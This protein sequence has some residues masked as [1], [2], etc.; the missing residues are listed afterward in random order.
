MIMFPVMQR[1]ILATVAFLLSGASLFAQ[2][3]DE[4]ASNIIHRDPFA[5]AFQHLDTNTP[6]LVLDCLT[7]PQIDYYC[8]VSGSGQSYRVRNTPFA[9]QASYSSQLDQTTLKALILAIAA[10]PEPPKELLASDRSLVVRGIRD[11]QWFKNIY[12]RAD[13]PKEVE[14]LFQIAGGHLEWYLRWP[15][16]EQITTNLGASE[17]HMARNAPKALLFA[18]TNLIVFDLDK[19][20]ILETIPRTEVLAYPDQGD[21]MQTRILSADGNILVDS[22]YGNRHGIYAYDLRTRK[23]LWRKDEARQLKYLNVG[24]DRWQSLFVGNGSSIERWDLASGNR[25]A[26]LAANLPVMNWTAISQDGRVFASGYG[27]GDLKATN[28]ATIWRTDEDKPVAKIDDIGHYGGVLSP[29]GRVLALTIS[30]AIEII[31]WQKGSRTKFPIRFPY[32]FHDS[33]GAVYWSPD[34]K[35]LEVALNEASRWL[36][37]IYETTA[38]KPKAILPYRAEFT[39]KG[40]LFQLNGHEGKHSVQDIYKVTE[41]QF[42]EDRK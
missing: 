34:G 7:A 15:E 40:D 12:D 26:V 22:I 17:F 13:I 41:A 11:N 5:A 23:I 25:E 16:S 8:Q 3:S 42:E 18:P 9:R 31:D 1:K 38:W 33:Q 29:D 6:L 32:G 36:W 35:Y 21:D 19:N 27:S 2:G 30:N 4:F 14:T 24:G 10:L 39:G 28:W 37:E 20:K